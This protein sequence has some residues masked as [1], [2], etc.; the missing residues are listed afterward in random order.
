MD[1][2][3]DNIPGAS[4]TIFTQDQFLVQKNYG[5]RDL[6]AKQLVESSTNFRTA[7]LT[8][9]FTAT[10]IMQLVDSEKLNL[11]ST[12]TELFATFPSYGSKITVHHLLSHTS[13]LLDYENLIPANYPGQVSDH[14][15][16]N[17]MRKQ[18]TTYFA[19][20]TRFRY[21]NTGYAIL[22]EIVQ[23]VSQTTFHRYLKEHIFDPLGMTQTVAFVKNE[24]SITN[25][26]YGYSL[27]TS[28]YRR[29]D[30]STTSAVLG[31]GG[32]YSSADD[33]IWWYRM[34]TG[35]PSVLT[36][37]SVNKMMT[38]NRLSNGSLTRYGY[39]WSVDNFEGHGRISH[40]GSTIGQKH[41]I[42]VF[43]KEKLGILIFTNRE[44]SAPWLI[45]DRIAKLILEKPPSH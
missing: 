20:G 8:K 10:A 38:P 40:T 28:G 19:P 45:A 35:G 4:V 34:W 5:L 29:T 2:D 16:L 33:F 30:E 39:G 31:D 32:I 11:N 7:S 17:L 25:R 18:R 9:A 22:A 43:P 12:L 3:G 24:N 27:L 13:G 37:N 14:D 21:S 41:V 1:Y 6:E 15:V 23:K 44:N 36:S 26:A 42:I